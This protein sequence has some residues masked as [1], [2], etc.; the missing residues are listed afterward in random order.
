MFESIENI[1]LINITGGIGSISRDYI[2]RPYHGLICKID[3]TSAYEFDTKTLMLHGGEIIYIPKGETYHVR[4]LTEGDGRYVAL[5]FDTEESLAPFTVGYSGSVDIKQLPRLWLMGDESDKYRCVSSFYYILSC[6][7]ASLGDSYNRK[8]EMI[9]PACEYLKKHI[10]RHSLNTGSLHSLCGISDV[11][12]RKLFSEVYGTSPRKYII[13]KRLTEAYSLIENG[14]CDNLYSIA[15][16]V[17]YDDP[18]YFS[19]EFKRKYGFSPSEVLYKN[20]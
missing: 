11:Y 8:V 1:K 10:F 13:D 3:G 4:K 2:R 12:F 16:T 19:R 15:Y 6:I 9:R 7:S 18:L 20:R 14:D 17:G 5:N